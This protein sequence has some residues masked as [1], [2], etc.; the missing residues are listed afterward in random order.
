MTEK[1]NSLF[2]PHA[3]L[4]YPFKQPNK[5]ASRPFEEIL[6]LHLRSLLPNPHPRP[7]ISLPWLSR[8]VNLLALTAAAAAAELISDPS[9]S[10]ADPAALASHLDASVALLDACNASLAEIERLRRGRLLLRFSLHLLTG[11]DHSLPLTPDRIRR[12]RKAIAE[13]ETLPRREVRGLAGDLTRRLAPGEPPRGKMSA[14]RR[15]LY[16]VEAVAGLVMATVVAVLSGGEEGAPAGVK[17][18][19]DF[20]WGEALKEV[21]VAVS[22]RLRT[23]FPGEVEAVEA[24]VRAVVGVIDGEDDGEKAARL[25]SAVEELEG[26]MEEVTEGLDPLSDAVNGLFRATMH[27]RDAALQSLRNGLKCDG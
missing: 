3:I 23:G 10:G 9:L 7:S 20:P 11:E 24:A 12:A 19:S 6:A 17:I 22:G 16:A 15:A 25:G 1:Y 2:K 14:V 26:A 13:W 4:R 8:A 21:E 18:S 27:T 5:T